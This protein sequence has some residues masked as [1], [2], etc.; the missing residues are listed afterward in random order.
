[1]WVSKKID[2]ND[3]RLVCVCPKVQNQTNS[4]IKAVM[5]NSNTD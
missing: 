2:N 1:M 5:E 4:P 3:K